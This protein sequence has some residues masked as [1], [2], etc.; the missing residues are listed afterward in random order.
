LTALRVS[1]DRE[2]HLAVPDASADNS[3]GLRVSIQPMRKPD[4]YPVDAPDQK[5]PHLRQQGLTARVIARMLGVRNGVV[6]GYVRAA[7][8]PCGADMAAAG[9]H[10]IRGAGAIAV[11]GAD[12]SLAKRPPSGPNWVYVEKEVAPAA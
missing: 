7:G 11:P 12:G 8:A 6:H 9:G 1:E 4:T 10:G 2:H 3:T 5:S